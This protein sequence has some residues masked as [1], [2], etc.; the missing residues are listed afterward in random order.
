MIQINF[1]YNKS[2]QNPNLRIYQKILKMNKIRVK[3]CYKKQMKIKENTK[4][5]WKK[6]T[7]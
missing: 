3:T 1:N 5:N 2:L 4:Q 7:F 6:K